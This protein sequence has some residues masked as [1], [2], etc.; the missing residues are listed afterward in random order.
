MQRL[1]LSSGK[2]IAPTPAGA[3]AA[4]QAPDGG[5]A[6]R[7]L[8]ALLSE[9]STPS[10]SSDGLRAWSG[11]EDDQEA[12]GLLYQLQSL[13]MVQSLAA[14]RQ[15][16]GASLEELL[17]GLISPLTQSGKALLANSQG[18]YMASIGFPHE[19]A[20][21]LSALSAD[22][23]SLQHRHQHLL[24]NNLGIASSNWA[25]VDG[26]GNSELGCWPLYIGTYRF[27]LVI[28]GTPHFNQQ[29]FVD[30]VWAL[31]HR[32]SSNAQAD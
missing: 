29:P 24:R 32:Y 13:A 16:P 20:E 21:E 7:L 18:F 28:A 31:T 4:T 30:L 5:A 12:A 9:G 27:V 22:L 25:M 8:R 6:R 19:T 17:P 15:V 1:D 26:A 23:A 10:L 14:P 2:F 11:I 3:Y